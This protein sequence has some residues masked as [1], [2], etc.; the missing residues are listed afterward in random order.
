MYNDRAKEWTDSPQG[1]QFSIMFSMKLDNFFPWS[2]AKEQIDSFNDSI[3]K[4][5]NLLQESALNHQ[6]TLHRLNRSIIQTADTIEN[7]H[8]NVTL[9]EETYNSYEAAYNRG[10][11][12][13]QN[14]NTARDNLSAAQNRLLS[15][16]Y[17]LA[18][19][20]LELEK[21]LNIPFGSLL[22]REL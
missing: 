10:A 18:L 22:S 13:F 8:L 2:P 7:M 16:Q 14:V 19:A 3:A 5:Q 15:E 4:Q 17:S 6:N 12:D 9:A 21:E 20:I 11:A 1:S